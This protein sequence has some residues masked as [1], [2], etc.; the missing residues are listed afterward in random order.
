MVAERERRKDQIQ[1]SISQ[2]ALEELV[3]VDG[4]TLSY[5]QRSSTVI[6]IILIWMAK[7]PQIFVISPPGGSELH[8]RHSKNA[9]KELDRR[10]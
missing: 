10:D 7:E 2:S 5:I 4:P 3:G 8:L 9:K 6:N 1:I